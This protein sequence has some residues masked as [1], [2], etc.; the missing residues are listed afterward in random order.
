MKRTFMPVSFLVV[1]VCISLQVR[2]A[3]STEDEHGPALGHR[4]AHEVLESL[5][6][7]QRKNAS[8]DLEVPAG[9]NRAASL[10]AEQVATLWNEDRHVDA[11]QA[12]EELEAKGITP[13][14][15]IA[16]KAPVPS[17][18][19]KY[20]PD[21]AIGGGRTGFED[22]ALGYDSASGNIFV[23]IQWADGWS[24][25]ISTDMGQSFSETFFWSTHALADM[26]VVGDHAWVGYAPTG[27]SAGSIRM[28]RFH[29]AD[30]A[31]DETYDWVE[32]EDIDPD[33]VA[34][35]I[36]ESN[37]PDTNNRIYVVYTSSWDRKIGILYDD[38]TGTSFDSI[39][40][41]ISFAWYG[42][43]FAWNPYPASPTD[44]TVWLSFIDST[45]NVQVYTNMN[46][47]VFVNEATQPFTGS[48]RTTGISAHNGDIYCVFEKDNGSGQDGVG[49]L[50]SSDAGAIWRIGD[51]YV[52][53]SGGASAR[54]PNVT[55]RS[56]AVPAVTFATAEA[57]TDLVF[58]TQRSAMSTGSWDGPFHFNSH[59]AAYATPNKIEW[60]DVP[61]VRSHGM[62]YGDD[63]GVPY[64]DLMTERCFFSDGF[65]SGNTSGW[66][67]TSW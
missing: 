63:A 37:A 59:P 64:F 33:Y 62:V 26:T 12:L 5:D 10:R 22:T 15:G 56:G 13:A 50:N 44:G 30:G 58:H 67:T 2:P 11:L 61:C 8:I 51:V 24:M 65:E 46:S 38:L 25:N 43:D 29:V 16:W 31:E 28:R 27:A 18:S 53:V 39:P 40:T 21:V 47:V 9:T 32:I 41:G 57:G 4:P 19:P 20:Y 36:V 45:P 14:V 3:R 42:L 49:Y 48:A 52:P 1:V 6:D 17:Q 55:V 34:D 7:A 35:L 23:L 66:S 54:R 60:L